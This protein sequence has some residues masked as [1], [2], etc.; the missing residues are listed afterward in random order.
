MLEPVALGVIYQRVE[1]FGLQKYR[2]ARAV[3]VLGGEL[4]RD[5]LPGGREEE[6]HEGC[7]TNYSLLLDCLISHFIFLAEFE[8]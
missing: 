4:G 2:V 8:C 6:R 3:A 7:F 5:S 1:D